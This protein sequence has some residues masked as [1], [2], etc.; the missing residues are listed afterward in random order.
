VSFTRSPLVRRQVDH[1]RL[2][3][4]PVEPGG[5]NAADQ[6]R[7]RDQGLHDPQGPLISVGDDGIAA[8]VAGDLAGRA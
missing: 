3:F 6:L 4:R 2:V 7:V 5:Q 1:A 8:V